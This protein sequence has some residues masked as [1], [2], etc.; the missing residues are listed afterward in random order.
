[1]QFLHVLLISVGSGLSAWIIKNFTDDE[2]ILDKVFKKPSKEIPEDRQ[3]DQ[4]I[5]QTL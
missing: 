3:K 2:K 4:I 5:C 1:M